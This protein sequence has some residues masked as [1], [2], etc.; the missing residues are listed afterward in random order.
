MLSNLLRWVTHFFLQTVALF[1]PQP[2]KF[3]ECL[4]LVTVVLYY[5]DIIF[6]IPG[7]LLQDWKYEPNIPIN[8]VFKYFESRLVPIF[9][10]FWELRKSH[11]K[12]N[13]VKCHKRHLD[14]NVKLQNRQKLLLYYFK[15]LMELISTGTLLVKNVKAQA[16]PILESSKQNCFELSWWKNFL[17]P[18]SKMVKMHFRSKS[19]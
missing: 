10:E 8:Q 1:L 5:L 19:L 2:F 17:K 16:R 6:L 11:A 12:K 4:L 14:F 9:Y 18:K 3:Y 15:S 7:S 13:T